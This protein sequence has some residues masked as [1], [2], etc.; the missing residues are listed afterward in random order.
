MT[1]PVTL[2][3]LDARLAAITAEMGEAPLRTAGSQLLNTSRDVSIAL[4]AGDANLIA[5]ADHIPVHVGAMPFAAR[6][7]LHASSD[8]IAPATASC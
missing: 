2:A 6:A 1:D 4:R 5:Q 3:V 7:V 8:A